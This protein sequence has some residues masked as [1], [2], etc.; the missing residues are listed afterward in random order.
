MDLLCN[1]AH[2]KLEFKTLCLAPGGC[3]SSPQAGGPVGRVPFKFALPRFAQKSMCTLFQ[4]ECASFFRTLP[5][6]TQARIA[7]NFDCDGLVSQTCLGNNPQSTITNWACNSSFNGLRNYPDS[8][9]RLADMTALL[10]APGFDDLGISAASS[11]SLVDLE[12]VPATCE[13]PAPLVVPEDPEAHTIQPGV[14]CAEVCEGTLFKEEDVNHAIN[15]TKVMSIMSF[16]GATLLLIAVLVK[17]YHQPLIGFFAF[18]SMNI[19][20][21]FLVPAFYNGGDT[22]SSWCKDNTQHFKQ[23]D[24]GICMYQSIWFCYWVLNAV[25]FWMIISFDSYQRVVKQKFTS[26]YTQF[27]HI[28]AWTWPCVVLVVLLGSNLAGYEPRTYWCLFGEA[29]AGHEDVKKGVELGLFYGSIVAMWVMGMVFLN[30]TI[31][32]KCKGKVDQETW[33][34]N[35][36]SINF[37]GLFSTVW[38]VLWGYKYIAA[39]ST[40]SVREGA[41]AWVRCLLTNFGTGIQDPATSPLA[42]NSLV[43]PF[44]IANGTGCGVSYPRAPGGFVLTALA[45]V[46]ILMQGVFLFLAFIMDMRKPGPE[47][48]SQGKTLDEGLVAADGGVSSANPAYRQNIKV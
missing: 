22:R 32:A 46:P 31:S 28:F 30:L 27:Y 24:G 36:A 7:A 35:F 15:M 47:R 40:E 16:I 3:A 9:Q 29:E 37:V 13:C 45:L 11:E 33:G 42:N 26:S 23:E 39:G 1:Q 44:G 38:A 2:M 18:A 4:S 14:C 21:A 43:Q 17:N 20:L 10:G 19:A 8:S 25:A 5:A 12:E 48:S 34:Y 41:T 6:A